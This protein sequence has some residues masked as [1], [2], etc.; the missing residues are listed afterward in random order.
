MKNLEPLKSCAA[1]CGLI[2]FGL[3]L[4]MPVEAVWAEAVAGKVVVIPVTSATLTESQELYQL[5]QVLDKLKQEKAGAV[6]FDLNASEGDAIAAATLV[7]GKVASIGIPVVAWINPSATGA[8]AVFALGSDAI[9]MS[10]LGTL[11]GIEMPMVAGDGEGERLRP[12]PGASSLAASVRSIA[13]AKGHDQTLAA[14]FV[15]PSAE[16]SGLVPK[17]ALL[18][19]TTAQAVE[20]GFAAKAD[21]LEEALEGR[22]FDQLEIVRVDGLRDFLRDTAVTSVE[23]KSGNQGADGAA[24]AEKP[25]P[26]G[27]GLFSKAEE[28]S[29]AGKIVVI[30]IEETDELMLKS[31]F[32]W[33]ERAIVKASDDGASAVILD[34]NTP[35]GMLWETQDLMMSILAKAKCQTITFVNPNAISAGSM[36]AISTDDIYMAP[37]SVIGAATVVTSM[38]G[39]LNESMEGK[40]SSVQI[41]A[42]RN[43][44]LLKGHNPEIAEA[45]AS[46][47]KTLKLG[48]VND[49]PDKPLTLNADQAVQIVNGKPLLAKGIANS[50]EDIIQQEGLTGEIHQAE[51]YGLEQFAMWVERLSSI[52]IVIGI[53]GAYLEIKAPG[54]GIP[55][56]VSVL[57]FTVF[58]FGNYVAGNLAGWEVAVVFA[59][60]LILVLLEV[61]ILPGTMIAGFIGMVLIVGSLGFA[62][63]DRVDFDMVREG[64]ESAPSWSGVLLRPALNLGIGLMLAGVLIMLAVTYLPKTRMMHWMVL[65]ATVGGGKDEITVPAEVSLVGKKGIAFTELRP[66]G[67][68][69]IDGEIVDVTSAAEFI[70]RGLPVAVV[71]HEGGRIVV[72][73]CG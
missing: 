1:A 24:I 39:D 23:A 22:G 60:G 30:K 42:V 6:V 35:G 69:E 7:R 16:I 18:T 25:V 65:D 20:V 52:L 32:A 31:R 47:E 56:L 59:L 55:G 49:G 43:M 66:S 61:F 70:E 50:I 10:A 4:L 41:A 68:A 63:I 28:E 3:S 45:F 34:M 5:G 51:P 57:A 36:I 13:E 67:K 37:A 33:F 72:E 71:V 11:G 73:H 8:G 12:A 17:D 54:F 46:P 14:A 29:F 38:G 2:L 64:S 58:F 19:L 53:A 15:D 21:T 62:M 27:D 26:R 48:P 44:A 40:V 9:V